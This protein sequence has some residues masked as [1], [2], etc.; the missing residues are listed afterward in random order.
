MPRL[1]HQTWFDPPYL[2][3][4]PKLAEIE[5]E[6]AKAPAFQW[7][8]LV[9]LD[10]A[11]S[12]AIGAE[13]AAAGA[14]SI[15]ETLAYMSIGRRSWDYTVWAEARVCNAGFVN[16]LRDALSDGRLEEVINGYELFEERELAN[17][18]RAG[19][20]LMTGVPFGTTVPEALAS[21]LRQIRGS[22]QY[23]SGTLGRLRYALKSRHEFFVST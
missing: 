23:A 11:I 8:R 22:N 3:P 13:L 2:L 21:Q 14:D 16:F 6:L 10:L 1:P 15:Q 19:Q 20:S 4:S 5:A 18:L 7:D 17:R 12:D 9:D